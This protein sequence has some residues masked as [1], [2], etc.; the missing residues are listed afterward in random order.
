MVFG[1][2]L[3][4]FKIIISGPNPEISDMLSMEVL[5]S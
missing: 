5:A 2:I 1:Q 3:Y 4:F